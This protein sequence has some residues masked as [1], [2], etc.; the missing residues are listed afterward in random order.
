MTAIYISDLD[1]TLLNSKPCLS[2]N[3]I[4]IVNNLI[5]QGMLFSIATARSYTSACDLIKPLKF[6]IPVI[7]HNGVFIYDVDKK[8]NIVSNYVNREIA[9]EILNISEENGVYPFLYTLT[10]ESEPKVYYKSSISQGQRD[11]IN[12]RIKAGDRRFHLVNSYKEAGNENI[13]SIV[14]IGDN[15]LEP[16]YKK[17]KSAYEMYY[18]Y[19]IDIY[20]KFYW[21]E[22]TNPKANK[23]DSVKLLKEYTNSDEVICFGDNLNDIL[24]FEASDY[25]YAVNNACP[26][27]KKYATEIIGNNNEDGVA[28]HLKKLWNHHNDHHEYNV[29]NGISI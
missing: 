8:N 29:N 28:E 13:I 26:E 17:L 1:G 19:S 27:I 21:L 16:L 11:Y 23:R 12:E 18:N 2:R 7:L 20:S 15:S 9:Y 22:I 4:K 14:S 3:T 10:Q 25:K 6:N 24:M 5:K